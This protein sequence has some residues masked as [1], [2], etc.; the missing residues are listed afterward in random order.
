MELWVDPFV[1]LGIW[2]HCGHF[3]L[4]ISKNGIIS[5]GSIIYCCFVLVWQSCPLWSGGR[6][7][8]RHLDHFAFHISI[9]Q[10]RVYWGGLRIFV[11]VPAGFSDHYGRY[12]LHKSQISRSL[13]PRSLFM[14]WR[15]SVKAL[16][17]AKASAAALPKVAKPS[18]HCITCFIFHR[19]LDIT[20]KWI[21]RILEFRKKSLSL[22][23]NSLSFRRQNLK[24]YREIF[25]FCFEIV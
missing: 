13:N 11:F 12:L 1:R 23:E 24:I 14:Y 8:W 5:S 18:G 2:L 21:W 7:L 6:L 25:C 15:R 22:R 17:V 3:W 20:N 9:Q 16:L 19:F 4:K 10:L